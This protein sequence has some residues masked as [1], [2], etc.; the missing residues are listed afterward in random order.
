MKVKVLRRTICDVADSLSASGIEA[1]RQTLQS[2][3]KLCEGYDEESVESFLAR[4]RHQPNQPALAVSSRTKT[5]NQVVVAR[6]VR[7]LQA[8]GMQRNAFDEVFG[9]LSKDTAVRKSE[10]DTIAHV[11]T[12]GRP[13]WPTKG[14]A[15]KAIETWFNSRAFDEAK[16]SRV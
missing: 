3:I 2:V 13:K 6:Y 11:Y 4:L 9:A 10:A 15:L 5:I 8:A 14:A 12:G 7:M 16:M 1:R